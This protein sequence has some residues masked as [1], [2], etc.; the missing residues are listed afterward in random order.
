MISDDGGLLSLTA[1][2]TFRRNGRAEGGG[3]G[4]GCRGALLEI[5]MGDHT[6]SPR[7]WQRQDTG[8]GGGGGLR[9][10]LFAKTHLLIIDGERV[11]RGG[12][13]RRE[14]SLTI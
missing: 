10:M 2:I 6:I 4:G 9:G 13:E 11:C 8:R 1:G 12:V 3:G 5:R 7:D 14:Y